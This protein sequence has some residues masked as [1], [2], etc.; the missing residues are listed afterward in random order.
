MNKEKKCSC[1]HELGHPC[2]LKSCWCDKH[3]EESIREYNKQ[4]KAVSIYSSKD[5]NNY[6]KRKN[7]QN[8]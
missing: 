2:N 6:E 5:V 1:R 4:N 3:W 8:F 7:I